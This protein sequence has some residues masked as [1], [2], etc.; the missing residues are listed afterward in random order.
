MTLQAVLS[1]LEGVSEENKA[2]YV[3]KDD[4][5]VLDI[6]GIENHPD[7]TPLSNAY[8]RTKTE[9]KSAKSD[10]FTANDKLKGL[11]EDFDLTVWN[12]AKDGPEDASAAIEAAK[13]E[14]RKEMQSEVDDWKGQ[15]Q[16]LQGTIRSTTAEN[17]LTD[18]LTKVGVT[19][20]TF[21]KASRSVLMQDVKFT[22]EGAPYF[23]GK[24]GPMDLADHIGRWAKED[25]KD[26]ITPPVGGGAKPGSKG[27]SNTQTPQSW[28]DAKTPA[29][30]AAFLKERA[31]A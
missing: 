7:I 1:N 31:E 14:V 16:G 18:A 4:K 19:N 2:L 29:E 26:F 9:L 13:I 5:F 11:P 20:E 30:K 24:L 3:E 23:D 6:T 22:D 17:Q 28:S 8:E 21:L 15:F 27:G 25:G 10:L 12:K